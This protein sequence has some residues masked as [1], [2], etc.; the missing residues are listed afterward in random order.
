MPSTLIHTLTIPRTKHFAHRLYWL[1]RKADEASM[2]QPLQ[3]QEATLPNTGNSNVTS[4][5]IIQEQQQYSSEKNSRLCQGIPNCS[6][7]RLKI[8]QSSQELMLPMIRILPVSSDK[9]KAPLP[10]QPALPVSIPLLPRDDLSEQSVNSDDIPDEQ[11]SSSMQ[12]HIQSSSI[13]VHM[14]RFI[15]PDLDRSE[16]VFMP[17]NPNGK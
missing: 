12:T 5:S 10:I 1:L 13:P 8:I 11:S 9:P 3:L 2:P 7:Q 16:L 6:E 17:P 4:S 14:E 15:A